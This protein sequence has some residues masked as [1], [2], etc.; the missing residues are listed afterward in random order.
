MTPNP[1]LSGTND[2]MDREKNVM[3]QSAPKHPSQYEAD[4]CIQSLHISSVSLSDVAAARK[5]FE[6]EELVIK[7]IEISEEADGV[8]VWYTGDTLTLDKAFECS[9]IPA[10]LYVEILQRQKINH[11]FDENLFLLEKQLEPCDIEG[12]ILTCLSRPKSNEPERNVKTLRA[13]NVGLKD[14]KIPSRQLSGQIGVGREKDR[15]VLEE[16]SQ[17][18]VNLRVDAAVQCDLMSCSCWLTV[19]GHQQQFLGLVLPKSDQTMITSLQHDKQINVIS[20]GLLSNPVK[21]AAFYIPEYSE[22]MDFTTAVHNGFIDAHAA[23]VLKSLEIPDELPDINDLNE[24]FSSWL[25]HKNV[26]VEGWQCSSEGAEVSKP[27]PTEVEQLFIS[28]LMINSYIDLKS[29]QRVLIL[30]SHLTRVAQAFLEDLKPT[31]VKM[32]SHLNRGIENTF[33]SDDVFKDN[34]NMTFDENS[35]LLFEPH[36]FSSVS[37][38]TKRFDAKPF[39]ADVLDNG[40]SVNT[41]EPMVQDEGQSKD[42]SNWNSLNYSEQKKYKNESEFEFENRFSLDGQSSPEI[43]GSSKF[44]MKSQCD[45]IDSESSFTSSLQ[46]P[47]FSKSVRVDNSQTEFLSFDHLKEKESPSDYSVPSMYGQRAAGCPSDKDPEGYCDFT[48]A[49]NRRA[50]DVKFAP[51]LDEPQLVEEMCIL[52][53]E[54]E[55]AC[56][57]NRSNP[58]K[59][60]QN[61]STF[62]CNQSSDLFPIV[63]SEN[64]NIDPQNSVYSHGNTFAFTSE[65]GR[66]F[67]PHFHKAENV[68]EPPERKVAVMFLDSPKEYSESADIDNEKKSE[69]RTDREHHSHQH[70]MNSPSSWSETPADC[71]PQAVNGTSML[72]ISEDLTS[73]AG[74][75]RTLVDSS[76]LTESVLTPYVCSDTQ[77]QHITSAFPSCQSSSPPTDDVLTDGLDAGLFVVPSFHN[78]MCAKNNTETD[79]SDARSSLD[80]D[81]ARSG[82]CSSSSW[83]LHA[84]GVMSPLEDCSNYDIRCTENSN[85][86][87]SPQQPGPLLRADFIVEPKPCCFQNAQIE[88]LTP[89]QLLSSSQSP[90]AL[91]NLNAEDISHMRCD[92]TDSIQTDEDFV[93]SNS[94][95]NYSEFQ[96][97]SLSLPRQ[98]GG[99]CEVFGDSGKNFASWQETSNDNG[100]ALCSD[101]PSATPDISFRHP[102]TEENAGSSCQ[103]DLKKVDE[104]FSD[105]SQVAANVLSESCN[106]ST[107]TSSESHSNSSQ[108]VSED[109]NENLL[110]DSVL[111]K[112]RDDLEL[113]DSQKSNAPGGVVD[114]SSLCLSSVIESQNTFDSNSKNKENSQLVCQEDAE[115]L[116]A[117][118][119]QQRFLQLFQTVSSG[120]DFSVL[121]EMMDSLSSGLGTSSMEER[122]HTLE[123]IQEESLEEEEEAAE[124]KS[125]AHYVAATVHRT[126]AHVSDFSEKVK[127]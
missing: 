101:P 71:C 81:P 60:L 110:K 64:N 32:L 120:Q 83:G 36:S 92:M 86:I 124:E 118:N 56:G 67:L 93:G 16:S 61:L 4:K 121:Q 54:E 58:T 26:S 73:G 33:Y 42:S 43:S 104:S 88:I 1:S 48:E 74:I 17:G 29:A 107:G 102:I 50:V 6:C 70:E 49:F 57:L 62:P 15:N 30:D 82:E 127:Q 100:N 23:E 80:G 18:G 35:H 79:R 40:G 123:S 94:K 96:N 66:I 38:K 105:H 5:G 108:I 95:R 59:I 122:W 51:E 55:T 2:H 25:I 112:D 39:T 115:H 90:T 68:Q 125:R 12:M 126:S 84:D 9:L 11:G 8:D 78:D 114:S 34:V 91:S 87:A 111:H 22:V 10:S 76:A 19:L 63:S 28:H 24:K 13:V 85:R 117:P 119:F 27:T 65:G 14:Q 109:C 37:T 3:Y 69:T 89:P 103:A 47:Y 44:S 52:K 45:V 98:H 53:A 97:E 72:I 31:G 106:A 46:K 21:M 75:S 7:V 20:S 99:T 113:L 41:I 77:S 116:D